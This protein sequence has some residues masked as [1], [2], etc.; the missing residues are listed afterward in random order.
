M[1]LNRLS[2]IKRLSAR[3]GLD[4]L[5]A[6]AL[7]SPAAFRN[8][9]S[10]SGLSF[11]E[12]D[13]LYESARDEREAALIYEK[14]LLARS[15]PL[16]KNAVRLGI[17][18]PDASLRDYEE[19]FGHRAS[20]YTL[21]GSVSSMF[22]PAAYLSALYRNARGLYPEESPYHIDKRRPDLKGLSLSQSNMNK[23][24]SALSLSN[25]VLM[26]LA[27][28]SL[29]L[30]VT[31]EGQ[32]SVL[33]WLST[34][35]LSGST[36]YHHPHARLRQSQIQKDPKFKQLAANPRVTGLF[37]G[38]TM[39]GMAFD[40]SPEVYAILT[41]E[42]TAGSADELY[43][44]NFGTIDP[45]TLITP[46][47]LRRYYGLS[48]EE[49]ALFS[50]DYANGEE[51]AEEYINNLLVTRVGD[52]IYR[53]HSGHPTN[54]LNYAWL[55]PQADGTWLL[56]FSF[57]DAQPDYNIFRVRVDTADAIIYAENQEWGDFVPGQSYTVRIE[58]SDLL[59][60]EFTM[61][62]RRYHYNGSY[63][64]G[65]VSYNVNIIDSFQFY[66]L[67][68]NKAIRLWRATGLHP[69]GLEVIVNSVNPVNITDETL[70]L[71]FQV[72]RCVQ[73][74]GVEPEEA[75]VLCGGLLSN[76]S[77]DDNQSLFDQVF[78]SPPLNGETFAPS[79]TPINLL[80]ANATDNTVEKA[81]LKRALN[82]DDVGLF[83]LLRIFDNA[84]SSGVLTLNLKNLSAMYALSRWAQL[85]ALSVTELEQ[86]LKAA[87]LPRLTSELENTQLWSGWLQNVDSLTQWLN[88]RKLSVADLDLLTRPTFTQAATTEIL[89]LLDELKGVI[90]AHPDADTL[91]KRIALLAPVLV[92]SLALPSAPVAESVL[93]W[94]NG[95]QP[96]EWTVDQFW[97]AAETDDDS[98]VAFCYGLA[99]L[100]LI[101]HATGINP[102]AFSL[103]V[104]TP[105]R[106]LGP[107]PE[108]AVLPR[109]LATVQ[110]LCNFSAWLKSL[111]DGASA[112]LAAF[113]ADTLTPA[114]LARALNDDATR[115][116]QATR[117]AY[118]NTQ[119]ASETKLSAWS[120]IDVVL[121][122][123]ALSTTFGVTP[124]NIG[125]LLALNYTAGN[126]PPWDDWVRVADAFTAGLTPYETKGMEAA[127]ASG[128]SAALCGYLLK[129]GMTAQLANNSR[130]GLYQYLLLDNL[131]GPQVM[132]SRVAEAIVSVQTFI[133]RTLS[134]AESQGTVDKAAVT[135]QFFTDWE[136]YNQRYSTWAG[137]AKLVYYPENY[138]DPTVRL[139]QSG[140]MNTMLQTLG[141]AQLNTDTVGDA[142]N[143]YL[144]SFEEV[145]NLRVISG[146]H[147]NLDVHEG[148][149]YFIGTNQS[150]VREFYWRSADEGRRSEDGQLAANAWTDWRKIECAAQPWGDC[151]RPVIYKS[152]LYLCWLERKDVTPPKADGSPGDSKMFDY[153]INISYLR[154]DG[155]W[156]SPKIID[157]TTD[158]KVFADGGEPP[159]LYC[160]SFDKETT[161]AV[162]LYKKAASYADQLPPLADMH[163]VYIYE[164]MASAPRQNSAETFISYMK[165]ELDTTTVNFINNKYAHGLS[166]GSESAHD[167]YRQYYNISVDGGVYALDENGSESD[168]LLSIGKR[169]EIVPV[170]PEILMRLYR[171][172]N[173][174]G[175]EAY[176]MVMYSDDGK[177]CFVRHGGK[178]YVATDFPRGHIFP[179]MVV[180]YIAEGL[181]TLSREDQYLE[182]DFLCMRFDDPFPDA[183]IGT[184]NDTFS[185][186]LTAVGWF[187]E[188]YTVPLY[189]FNTFCPIP[190]ESIQLDVYDG[191]THNTFSA[192]EYVDPLP[193][194]DLN[195]MVYDFKNISNV[196]VAKNWGPLPSH[197]LAFTLS[198]GGLDSSDRI[199][200]L[201]PITRNASDATNIIK[202]KNTPEKAQY[203]E[204]DACRTRLNTLF[205]RQL[206]ERAASGIDTILSYETQ[207]IQEPQ[208][209]AGF[210]TNINLP[211]Y[212]PEA[213]GDEHWVKI[214]YSYF[215]KASDS[216]LA[217]TGNLN[218]TSTTPLRLFVPYPDDG[219]QQGQAIHL[220]VQYKGNDNTGAI[221][222]SI[223][224][225]YTPGNEAAT[226]TRPTTAMPLPDV[227]HSV[228]V[229]SNRSIS[230]DFSG[231]N[232]L[233]FWE[234]FYYTPMMAAQRFL[235][236][237]QF[238]LADQWL[239]YVWSPS[240]YVVRG[241]HVDRNW[242]VRPLQEDTSWNDAPLKAVDPDAVAQNDPMHYKV[243]TFMR[244][245]D[246]LIARGD[247]AYRKLE[248]DTLAEAKVW[249]SQ[250]LNLLG[251]QPYIRANALWAEPSLGE[252]SSEALAEQHLTVLSLLREGRVLTLK[253][254]ASKKTAAAS[255][256]F[257]P[258]VNEVMQGYWL[259]LRQRMYN[260]RHNLTLDGQPLLLP[261]FAKPADPKALL[262]AAVAAESSG[263]SDL[264]VTSLPLWRFEPM[265]DSARGLVFQL[266]QF[267]NAVLGVLERQDAESLNALL[268]NQGTELMASTIQVQEGTLRELEAE[269]K[270]L[271]RSKD[272]AQ[273]RFDSY[274]RLYDENINSRERLSISSLENAK[275]LGA[276][277]KAAY[278]AAAA[279]DLA[280]NIFGLAN[281]GMKFGAVG[282]MAGLGISISAENL[283]MDSS[284]I[285]QEEIYRRRREEW[286][287]QRNNA[288]GEIQQIEAQLASLE[289]RRESTELQKAHLE[290]QQGQAQAQLDFLQTKFSNSA[291][292]SWLRGRLATIYF[293][294]YDLA[295]SRCLMAEKAWHWESGK[296]D[297]YIRGGGWQG[298]WAG[299]TCGEGLMLNLAQLETARMKWSKRALEITRTVSL[300]DFYRSTL[301]E[302]D[303]FELSAAVSALLNGDTPP[304]GSAERV[305]L[306]ESG[307][308]TASITLADLNIVDDYPGGLGDQRR[309]KQVS[310]SLPAL[311]GPYQDVQAVLNYTGGGNV[312]PPGCDNMA[313]SRGVN[314]SGQFQP[315]FNDP[316]WLPF[317]GADIREGSMIIS[318]PQAET[319]QK[320]LLESLNDI[321]LHINYTIRS[322]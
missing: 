64:G 252:A 80:P 287:I 211:V 30:D 319:K 288:E 25:E 230:M 73:R 278:I 262:N 181:T 139:G 55:L 35:R 292:Y 160:T 2:R 117:Q 34:Y 97:D 21:P 94:A 176:F 54:T 127:L 146:Y 189:T 104:A 128:L 253:S 192:R 48:D 102:Q 314:D 191:A 178:I 116:E 300:A 243:A 170:I 109:A 143:T 108:V 125:Q 61:S 65:V 204:F 141:Q 317:E 40:I 214:Y 135:G 296:S 113:V 9:L 277:A 257:L 297:T 101:Y 148:K 93:A 289:V 209:G 316:R 68:L 171:F 167:V 50:T 3:A 208:L 201:V 166:L 155:N 291:L 242:N 47:S 58:A 320:A 180:N 269:K 283:M 39:A 88:S 15:S 247:S 145:A 275:S 177:K 136:R 153:A 266:I 172:D 194:F 81:I 313:I 44:R 131:N 51:G 294:F 206:V 66:V 134:A 309:I 129:S 179:A 281:G 12:V 8:K 312:L 231:A 162:L 78:N 240:G 118:A 37:S 279:L 306:D 52:K 164:D 272:S 16:L 229:D 241:Q 67:K 158:I 321:I 258:E 7:I 222:R 263:G 144:N 60:G 63:V 163:L 31:A 107:V 92:S 105:A 182:G 57:S 224:F 193:P 75:L 84:A 106:L 46:Q 74:Y 234:L 137:A 43:A 103:F 276:G 232:A 77:Y 168:A 115:F 23:E 119:A 59:Q 198:I 150:E 124:V 152:R 259:T 303:Q 112:V 223:M 322:L 299:L 1:G 265:L 217:W 290:M 212:D 301:A 284:R 120:E 268:Q 187:Y 227:A 255:A 4:S 207:E 45:E 215:F 53:L 286:E 42:V 216:Y 56:R 203:M 210:F 11:C 280:P 91:E 14:C 302:T 156:T 24:V 254:M 76:N 273:R 228:S 100:A 218:T 295:V 226:V 111:G 233:Y 307:A 82:V 149:T 114:D 132:T 36:P 96:A 33:E 70:Q 20:S 22:S 26:T 200:W 282:T 220:R 197:D 184:V 235:Q 85:H 90:S 161:M 98:V 264:P 270:V 6:Q 142:F 195:G 219:W 99:Q 311:L 315:D 122:W 5:A 121:Q 225:S 236:E 202:I 249:Y 183:L 285:S 174:L 151:I 10:T 256:L 62:L 110:A 19:Q 169:C 237:Q 239:R 196:K 271:S 159:G 71:L 49:V 126:Q 72:Q 157:V 251:E 244:A 79:T 83:A 245:L 190:H 274:S 267:G 186:K 165:Y 130:E 13:E 246:L 140:M 87:G 310:V 318:F 188:F 305:R 86:L 248:R 69:K 173:S 28:E 95:L 175:D 260:L 238:T 38:A 205:A 213:H 298:T 221:G 250:A 89:A 154:Y 133:Q 32:G 138:V 41:E 304:E 27:G 308:L 18:P 29:K 147:D 17:N 123:A 185:V 293:Q 199:Q 261:L